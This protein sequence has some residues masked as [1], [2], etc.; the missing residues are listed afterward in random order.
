VDDFIG[1]FWFFMIGGLLLVGLVV[2]LFV[3]R[4]RREED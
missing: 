2:L 1:S 4:N 3:L